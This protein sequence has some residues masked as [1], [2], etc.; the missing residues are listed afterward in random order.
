VQASPAEAGTLHVMSPRL[1]A[2]VLVVTAAVGCSS[3]DPKT[4]AT[5]EPSLSPTAPATAS[6]T[7]S[8]TAYPVASPTTSPTT[9]AA[10]AP[11][12]ILEPDGLGVLVGS[13]SIRHF[14]FATTTATD[15]KAI[16]A[17]VLGAGKTTPL[18]ECGQGSRTSFQVQRFQLLLDGQRF[19]GWTNQGTPGHPLSSA[20]GIRLGI[21]LAKL[22]TLEKVT[23]NEESLGAEFGGSF[24][25]FLSG[26]KS[27]SLVT[28]L[29]AGE[30]CFFR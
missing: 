18:P 23:L 5:F 22:K 24:S 9:T 6:P 21:T 17:R 2:L 14:P 26:T 7:P 11:V 20:N 13:S 12:L 1:A 28:A 10:T 16:V 15:I 19:V 27:S 29:Y 8:P 30:T 4:A 25:G 3:Q